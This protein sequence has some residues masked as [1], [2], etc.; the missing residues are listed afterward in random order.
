VEI[1]T[2]LSGEEIKARSIEIIAQELGPWKP[3][4]KHQILFSDEAQKF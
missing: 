3:L 2:G 4:A 1:V